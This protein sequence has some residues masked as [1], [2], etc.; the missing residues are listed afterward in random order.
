MANNASRAA[1]ANEANWNSASN[2]K[3][4]VNYLNN[5]FGSPGNSL[6]PSYTNVGLQGRPTLPILNKNLARRSHYI[7]RNVVPSPYVKIEP[8]KPTPFSAN[9]QINKTHKGKVYGLKPENILNRYRF[10]KNLFAKELQGKQYNLKQMNLESA[11]HGAQLQQEINVANSIQKRT[12]KNL[13][14]AT[15]L[16]RQANL[17]VIAAKQKKNIKSQQLTAEHDT[18]RRQLFPRPQKK[19]GRRNRKT[20]RN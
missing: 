10:Q 2:I 15:R 13:N 3:G 9:L 14:E 5:A 7:E 17:N 18:R 8:N 12:Q 1:N 11:K 20:R 16:A 19:L 6:D 4:R